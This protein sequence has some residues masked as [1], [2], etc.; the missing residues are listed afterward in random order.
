MNISFEV[1]PPKKEGS[2]ETA[3][4]VVKRLSLLAPEFISV[5]YG[6][7]GSESKKTLDIASYIQ[8]E[9]NTEAVAHLT[10]IGNTHE[11]ILAKCQEFQKKNIHNVLALRGDRPK[12]MTDEQF[13]RRE[14]AHATDMI[15]FL[16]ENSKLRIMAACYPEKHF[17]ADSMEEDLQYMKEKQDLGVES[18]LSQLF[19]DNGCFYKFREQAQQIGI[20]KPVCAGIMPITTAKQIGTTVKLSGSSVPKGLAD[21]IAKYSESPEGMYKAGIDYAIRQIADLQNNAVDG[22][23]IYTMNKPQVAEEIVKN[24]Q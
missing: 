19:F 6:A 9:C 14:F 20:T 15:R 13:N 22:V 23:H 10:C 1:Y 21:I 3:F 8:N 7:G 18:F 24:L 16:R 12:D 11:E 2:F 17:E 4:D 5:T